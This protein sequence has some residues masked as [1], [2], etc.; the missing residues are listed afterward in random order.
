[1]IPDLDAGLRGYFSAFARLLDH[2]QVTSDRGEPVALD[3]AVDSIVDL[4]VSVK[5]SGAKVLLIGN[6]GSAALV[7]HTQNDL[8]KMVGARAMV[9]T[10]GPLLTATAN[11]DG[12][13]AV[14]HRPVELWADP[15]DLLIAVSSSGESENIVRAAA[16]ARAKGCRVV[17]MTGFS[18]TNRLRQLG[19]LNVYVPASTYGYVET[20][21]ALIAHCVTDMAVLRAAMPVR[22]DARIS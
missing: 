10:E 13:Q 20:A 2:V 17:T 21:H 3:A 4:I 16:A 11:D 22:L 6:G 7:S 14:F 18:A 12:Y 5:D 19:V 8:C 1:M 9:F 15:H